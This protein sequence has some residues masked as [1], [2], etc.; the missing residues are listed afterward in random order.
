[1][2]NLDRT[3][4]LLAL[5]FMLLMSY[6]ARS[7]QTPVPLA[8]NEEMI[9]TED[10]LALNDAMRSMLD[11]YVKPVKGKEK[12]AE[13]LYNLMFGVDK[14]GLKYDNGL[15]KTAIETVESGSGNCVS[16]ANAF[17]A[18]ARYVD[19]NAN[20]LDVKVP[21]SW[22][23][24]ADIYYQLKHVSASVK[25]SRS[26]YLGIEYLW[27]G[28]LSSSKPKIVDD[29]RAFAVFYSNRGI[30]LLMQGKMEPAVAHLKQAVKLDPDSANNWSN[31]GVAYRR[32]DRLEEAEGAY[33]QALRQDKSDLTT[34]SNL[35][36]LYEMTGRQ[37]LADKYSKRLE[38]YRRQNPYYLIDLAKDEMKAGN[39]EQA[40]EYAEDAIHKYDDEHEF[41][42]VAAQI[43]AHMGDS[44]KARQ[45]LENAERYAL[46]AT[47]RNMYSRKLEM[48]GG[49]RA[50][51][52]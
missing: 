24:E 34:L 7:E 16:L 15:T 51:R 49:R 43:Y 9:K 17:V 42:F 27:M 6:P 44:E 14:F 46:S 32:L 39:Y 47:A 19:L 40:L 33:L 52:N 50:S 13:A 45:N 10:I 37:N 5:A 30:E 3:V 2:F 48:L 26:N 35:A 11:T 41:Y 25:I 29:E 8:G 36:I 22:K 12:R 38:R 23:R 21:E 18:M 4:S 1:M 31:L 20:F 28:S